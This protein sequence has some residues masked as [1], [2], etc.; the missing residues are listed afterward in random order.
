MSS[1]LP[2]TASTLG[3]EM[4]ASG[5]FRRQGGVCLKG[6]SPSAEAGTEPTGAKVTAEPP[7]GR[8]LHYPYR[9]PPEPG[10]NRGA[11]RSEAINTSAGTVLAKECLSV[12]GSVGWA[13]LCASWSCVPLCLCE[14]CLGV[15]RI[16]DPPL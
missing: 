14:P 12:L 15:T 2:G 11:A 3:N 9:P 4:L 6:G 16:R 8:L 1:Q 10:L 5:C 13:G 7:Q